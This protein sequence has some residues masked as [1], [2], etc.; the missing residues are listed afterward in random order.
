MKFY[1]LNFGFMNVL[2]N[3]CIS[4]LHSPDQEFRT[5]SIQRFFVTLIKKELNLGI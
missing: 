5:K 3:Y 1:E 2:Q 4:I